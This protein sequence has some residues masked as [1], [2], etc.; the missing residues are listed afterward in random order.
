MKGVEAYEEVV[1]E[2]SISFGDGEIVKD[3]GRSRERTKA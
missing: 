1:W 2:L 3:P